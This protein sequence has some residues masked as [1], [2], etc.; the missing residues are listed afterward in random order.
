MSGDGITLA[1]GA[2]TAAFPDEVV[3][4][5]LPRDVALP[6]GAGTLVLITLDNGHDHTRP[7][8]LGPASL[9][10]LEGAIDTTL[11]RADVV[12]LAVT[13]KPYVFAAGADLTGAAAIRDRDQARAIARLGHRVLGK[14]GTAAIPTFAFWNG[15]AL[16]GGV[17]VGLHCTYRT[18]SSGVTA[19]ALPETS[20][21][22]VPGWGGCYL[23]PRLIGPQRAVKV[24]IEN[25]LA[26]NTTL[27]ATEVAELGLA[28]AI[29]EPA[30]Y[31]EHSIRW[32]ARII[33]GDL[34]VDR[35]SHDPTQAWAAAVDRGKAI[36]RA[37]VGGATPAPYRALQLLESAQHSTRDV[38]FAAEDEAL[39]D[40]IMSDEFRSSIYAFDLVQRRAK[41]PAGAPDPSV[42]RE[43]TKVGVIG[44]GLMASQL[45]LLFARRLNVPVVLTDVDQDRVD[46]GLGFVGH[47]VDELRAKG[48]I[49]ADNARRLVGAITGRV[50]LDDFADADLVIE[51]VFEDLAVKRRVLADA[52]AVVG[53]QCVLATNTSSLSV[54]AMA[55]GLA[56]PER[57]VGMHFF[58]PVA[59]MPLLEIVRSPSTNEPTVATALSVG[60]SLR[61]SCIIVSDAPGFVVNRLLAR[62]LG[63]VNR[64]V[65]EG[66]SIEVADRALAPLGLPMTPFELLDLTGPA[67]S[68]HVGET[69]HAAFPDR[70][71]ISPT[72]QAMV[73]A[74]V[75][76][77]WTGDGVSRA[78]DPTVGALVPGGAGR[79]ETEVRE[80]ALAALAD[81]MRRMLDDEVVADVRDIDLAMILGAGWP[82][83]LG[84]IA[85]FLD[86]SGVAETITGQRF[87][88]LGVASVASP[89]GTRPVGGDALPVAGSGEADDSPLA[90]VPT[91]AYE[92]VGGTLTSR[93][94]VL[95]L[96][97]VDVPGD[98]AS[99]GD[100]ELRVKFAM[101]F[102]VGQIA[103][104]TGKTLPVPVSMFT[105]VLAAVGA[106]TPIAVRAVKVLSAAQGMAT[107][108]LAGDVAYSTAALPYPDEHVVIT[109]T[110]DVA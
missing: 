107:L 66:T 94:L 20:I 60:Q 90:R 30:D 79:S 110:V 65:D 103:M 49:S 18:I 83:H 59:V 2:L 101:P 36:A 46:R 75:T 105:A 74:G 44:A 4:R 98:P 29:F 26:R 21:G 27:R 16:G 99:G 40:L 97:P 82:F 24:I 17:E 19:F 95:R 108:E 91:G 37:R 106:E 58:N 109:A 52:E 15:V 102:P 85:P 86:R 57:L 61:K 50:G 23:V 64:A 54:A 8:T 32:A 62:L 22:L 71:A 93:G 104:F 11:A 13:G 3:T 10:S 56:H 28:D 39:T 53:A 78:V 34:R 7:N 72:M 96:A 84:G 5:A 81:E 89:E 47:Q 42:A 31:L 80:R 45:A 41:R 6:G 63:E 77:V 25:S 43:V 92:P 76:K 68:L 35:P 70:Y 33:T 87:L 38:A 48:R 55:E 14:L 73:A 1:D 12:G 100:R 67:V 51:A 69:M 9:L 88:P